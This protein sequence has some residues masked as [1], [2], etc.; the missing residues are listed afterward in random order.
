LKNGSSA[1]TV[2]FGILSDEVDAGDPANDAGTFNE[3]KASTNIIED[4]PPMKLEADVRHSYQQT[5]WKRGA[6]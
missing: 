1:S 5:G 4:V 2:A 6:P 3:F